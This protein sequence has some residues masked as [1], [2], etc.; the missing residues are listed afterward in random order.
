MGSGGLVKM[1]AQMRRIDPHIYSQGIGEM[2]HQLVL[3]DDF[4]SSNI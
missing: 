4:T 1:V 3:E 2:L